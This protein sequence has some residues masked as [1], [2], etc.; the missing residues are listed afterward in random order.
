M[1]KDKIIEIALP[2]FES[3]IPPK[4]IDPEEEWVGMPEFKQE[5]KTSWKSIIVHFETYDD[6]KKFAVLVGQVLT[7]R[8]R[9]IWYPKAKISRMDEEYRIDES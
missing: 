9:S 6:L 8:T 1:A 7:P 3:I 2:G 4:P 5:D